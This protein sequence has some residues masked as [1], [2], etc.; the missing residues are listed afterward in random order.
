MLNARLEVRLTPKIKREVDRLVGDSRFVTISEWFRA[1]VHEKYIE[2]Y[3]QA[4]ISPDD[5]VDYLVQ[6]GAIDSYREYATWVINT[7]RPE[8]AQE[9]VNQ[10]CDT[11]PVDELIDWAKKYHE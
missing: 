11:P 4:W 1:L 5:W 7:P 10:P 9:L 3:G 2:T 6:S 8:I